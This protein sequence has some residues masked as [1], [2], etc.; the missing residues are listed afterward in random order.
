MLN[1]EFKKQH[2][3]TV[4]A[5]ADKAADPFIKQRLHDL[6]ARYE[7]DEG[8]RSPTTLTPIDLQF[9]SQG[10]GPRA[11]EDRSPGAISRDGA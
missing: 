1:S 7:D 4:R 6:A 10:N 3:R 9:T 11:I 8:A 2:A 5:L